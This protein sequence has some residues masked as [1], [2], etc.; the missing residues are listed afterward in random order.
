LHGISRDK[1]EIYVNLVTKEAIS[2]DPL[3]TSRSAMSF[4]ISDSQM[5]VSEIYD[6]TAS[7]YVTGWSKR[8]KCA[9]PFMGLL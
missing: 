4:P 2:Q 8:L 3:S 1:A 5:I 7:Y 6:H 9:K